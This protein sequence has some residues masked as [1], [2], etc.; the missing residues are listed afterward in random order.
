MASAILLTPKG[1]WMG[2]GSTKRPLHGRND[3]HSTVL[4]AGRRV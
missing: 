1:M 2:L 4:E 3:D